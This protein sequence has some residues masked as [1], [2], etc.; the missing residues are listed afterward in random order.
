MRLLNRCKCGCD[1]VLKEDFWPS[2][3]DPNGAMWR[4][5]LD[6]EVRDGRM[7]PKEREEMLLPVRLEKEEMLCPG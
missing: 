5:Y 2:L 7:T 6:H 1:R 4:L 3:E